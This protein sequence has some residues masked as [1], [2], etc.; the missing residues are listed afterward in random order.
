[1]TIQIS[2]NDYEAEYATIENGKASVFVNGI[3]AVDALAWGNSV[4]LAVDGAEY[5][6]T[7]LLIVQKSDSGCAILWAV[8]VSD[9]S[10]LE[11][12]LAEANATIAEQNS[13]LS[14]IRT[15]LDD[16]GDGVTLTKLKTFL[17]AVKQAVNYESADA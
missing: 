2:G 10:R 15:A 7:E 11:S 13:K 14:A 3:T 8:E 4:A 9:T 16:L 6:T 17:A 5:K 1:M 12:E